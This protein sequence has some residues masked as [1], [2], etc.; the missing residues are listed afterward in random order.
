MRPN[1]V[2]EFADIETFLEQWSSTKDNKATRCRQGCSTGTDWKHNWS[3]RMYHRRLRVQ[4]KENGHLL[5][6]ELSAGLALTFRL[7]CA[8]LGPVRT[9]RA[10]DKLSAAGSLRVSR[11]VEWGSWNRLGMSDGVCDCRGRRMAAQGLWRWDMFRR[12]KQSVRTRAI[13]CGGLQASGEARRLP[14][15]C[16]WQRMALARC[17]VANVGFR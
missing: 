17:S 8:N 4:L 5:Y 7:L 10:L 6:R 14:S 11:P 15:C 2:V 3:I 9:S 13:M 16:R 1:T 12:M